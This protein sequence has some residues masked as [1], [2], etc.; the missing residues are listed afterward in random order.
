M[1]DI[2]AEIKLAPPRN[3]SAHWTSVSDCRI[4]ANWEVSNHCNTATSGPNCFVDSYQLTWQL[5]ASGSGSSTNVTPGSSTGH[6]I[7]SLPCGDAN[8]DLT[9]KSV[10]GTRE[11]T[12]LN[13]TTTTP[14]VNATNLV[15]SNIGINTL[16]LNWIK[17]VS[18]SL[19]TQNLYQNGTLIDDFDNLTQ[20]T[21]LVGLLASTDYTFKLTS[22]NSNGDESSG[23]T[24]V[25]TTNGASSDTTPPTG[26]V[27]INNG[28]TYTI[29]NL[30]NL[31]LTT[32]D[33]VW[34]QFSNA[35]S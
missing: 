22:L 28:A 13:A 4:E 33:A 6:T 20:A 31:T 24:V 30:V 18:G 8:Y 27:S 3:F 5:S 29:S 10:F 21:S 11:S 17:S 12:I 14:P 26:S 9:L 25:C 23:I 35:S 15:C 32:D 16:D 1:T 7:L 34:M 19:D 2:N